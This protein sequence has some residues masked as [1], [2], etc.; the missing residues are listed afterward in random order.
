MIGYDIINNTRNSTTTIASTIMQIPEQQRGAN[1]ARCCHGIKQ[2]E[3]IDNR[4][5][6]FTII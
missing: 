2:Y 4:Y 6:F 3:V 5:T 1:D